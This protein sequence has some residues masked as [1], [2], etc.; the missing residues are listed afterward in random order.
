MNSITRFLMV[1]ALFCTMFGLLSG[2]A[3][4]QRGGGGTNPVAL[5]LTFTSFVNVNGK[6]PSWS[7][8]YNITAPTIIYWA[9]TT[10]LNFSIRAKN[11]NLPDGT[12]LY[13][14]LYTSDSLTGSST[15]TS[16]VQY[17]CMAS[18]MGVVAKLAIV[19]AKHDFNDDPFGPLIIRKL[20]RIEVKDASGAVLATCIP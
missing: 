5:P 10:T 8:D 6:T 2:Q 11:M 14:N 12:M 13:V 4:A 15:E 1:A 17:H 9:R 16:N 3:Q 20:D 18:P 19:K 7:G